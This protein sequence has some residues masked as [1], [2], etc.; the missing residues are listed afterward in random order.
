MIFFPPFTVFVSHHKITALS[1]FL[2]RLFFHQIITFELLPSIILLSH[3]A[4]TAG[5]HDDVSL[6]LFSSHPKID[7]L[8]FHPSTTL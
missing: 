5:A 3:Q 7:T 6:I 4:I 8:S 1:A 2:I